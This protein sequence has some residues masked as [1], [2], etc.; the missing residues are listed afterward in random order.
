V[1]TTKFM[2]GLDFVVEQS[3]VGLSEKSHQGFDEANIADELSRER[4]KALKE[5]AHF[6]EGADDLVRVPTLR[7]GPEIFRCVNEIRDFAGRW[8]PGLSARSMTVP[9]QP[10]GEQRRDLRQLPCRTSH[11]RAYCKSNHHPPL[12]LH[13]T[14][15]CV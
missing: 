7:R 12:T 10:D 15:C 14:G 13:R 11:S 1:H 5:P 3:L 9:S 8:E 2:E 4:R 6:G